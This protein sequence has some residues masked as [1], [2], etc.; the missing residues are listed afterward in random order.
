M[1]KR[2]GTREYYY[3]K[4]NYLKMKRKSKILLIVGNDKLGRELIYKLGTKHSILLALYDSFNLKRIFKLIF[5]N[6]TL[7]LMAFI[8]M[9]F[10][11]LFRRDYKIPII[12]KVYNNND[13]FRLINNNK[14]TKIFLFRIGIIINKNLL[15]TNTDFFNVHCARLPEYGG[16]GQIHRILNEK[17]F[18]QEATIHKIVEKIDA[19][20]IIAKIPYV[21][22]KRLSYVENEHIAYEAGMDLLISHL[23]NIVD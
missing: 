16:I 1:E 3:R 19:G 7:S 22:D 10:A 6:K 2:E 12:T 8:K 4:A 5:K 14:I 20:E 18:I 11:E 13:I 17:A 9:S 23:E 21:L 15:S